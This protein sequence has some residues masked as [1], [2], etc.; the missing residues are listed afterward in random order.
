MQ[1]KDMLKKV[2][3]SN[4]RQRLTTVASFF[5]AYIIMLTGIFSYF[6][7]EDVSTKRLHSVNNQ[8]MGSIVAVI[9]PSWNSG[10]SAVANGY[11]PG[12]MIQKDPMAMNVS[13]STGEAMEEYVRLVL[14]VSFPNEQG[15]SDIIL[16][17]MMLDNGTEETGDDV[18]LLTKQDDEYICNNP[19]YS[20]VQQNGKFY[21]YYVNGQ[22]MK[23][24]TT[25]TG[26]SM[27]APLFDY[28]QIP[29][30]GDDYKGTFD[31]AFNIIVAAQA[32]AAEGD[33]PLSVTEAAGKF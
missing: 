28:V 22:N 24:L 4:W 23:K 11:Q 27:S 10:G 15:K 2:A 25:E 5:I 17:S 20:M 12:A 30:S 32:I 13:E 8:S 1:V 3:V 31:K 29:E 21:F 14:S 7:G 26:E 16:A 6:H 33:E 19:N 18:P 9:E